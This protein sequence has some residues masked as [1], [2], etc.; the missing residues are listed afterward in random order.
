MNQKSILI[1]ED[2]T[3]IQAIA[4]FSLEMDGHWQVTVADSGVEGLSKAKLTT[5][6]VILLDSMLL[7]MEIT[8]VL[9]K[10]KLDRKARNIPIILFTTKLIDMKLV[11]NLNNHVIGIISKPFNSLTLSSEI[12]NLLVVDYS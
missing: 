8:E 2:N 9:E 11:K 6:N 4:K 1:I 10:F 5:P 12:S 3:D 7:D